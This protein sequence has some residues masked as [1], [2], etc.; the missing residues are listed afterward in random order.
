MGYEIREMSFAEVLDTGFKLLRNHF[1]LLVGMA[2][3][4]YMPMAFIT[5]AFQDPD[6]PAPESMAS[7]TAM[8]GGLSIGLPLAMIGT[9]VVF[10]GITWAIGQIYLGRPVTTGE[11]LQRGLQRL[12][13]LFGTSFLYFFFV[14]LGFLL[15]IL[16]GI[17]LSLGYILLYP[18]MLIEDTFGMRALRRSR[19]LM[20][21]HMWRGFGI[22]VVMTLISGIVSGGLDFAFGTIPLLG[23]LASGIGQA[24]AGAYGSAVLVVL[25]F[26][27]R[28]RM[29]AFDLEHLAAQVSERAAL[30]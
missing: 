1:G 16:P 14:A 20:R 19:A 2:A 13:P 9:T 3:I 7:I 12:L 17:Y 6:A 5:A 30:A 11:S 21:G 22:L 24:L 8:L 15:F 18:V 27:S 29:E 23:P 25:Y 10:A 4:V 26:D 28:C